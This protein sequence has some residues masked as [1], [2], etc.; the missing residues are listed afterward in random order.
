VSEALQLAVEIE[1]GS[2]RPKKGYYASDGAR[3]PSAS[4]IADRFGNPRG[5]YWWHYQNGVEGREFG[6]GK[7]PSLEIGSL[8]H[9]TIECEI[10]C[11]PVPTVP[12]YMREQV[13]SAVAA[14][15]EWFLS[16]SLT[17]VATE[18][19]LVSESY[20]FGGTLDSVCLDRHGRYCI[21]DW[22]S[23]KGLYANYLVQIAA[24]KLLWEEN[25]WP[26]D[27]GF[28]LVRFSK[29]HGDMEHRYYPE[30]RIAEELFVLLREAYELDKAVEKRVK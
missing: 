21:G 11:E 24:Y 17:I 5:L 27:G 26:I 12:E 15:H 7:E 3:L 25:R 1:R 2:G 8:V 18:V 22:K 28:H 23:S 30:L 19:P 9:R 4:T 16:N 14:W 29:E 13:A 10:N 6:K 20:R